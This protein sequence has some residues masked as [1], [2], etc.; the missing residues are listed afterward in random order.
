MSKL[1][2]LIEDEHTEYSD[3]CTSCCSDSCSSKEDLEEGYVSFEEMEARL[4]R[5]TGINIF[6]RVEKR[7]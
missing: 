4:S 7:C 5:K 6:D 2:R 1:R 3:N